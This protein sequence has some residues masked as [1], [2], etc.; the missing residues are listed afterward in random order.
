MDDKNFAELLKAL[1]K[2]K[3]AEDE[4]ALEIPAPEIKARKAHA[5]KT[6]W[7]KWLEI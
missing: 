6:F 7:Q 3:K 1:G 2:D 5:G 4:A